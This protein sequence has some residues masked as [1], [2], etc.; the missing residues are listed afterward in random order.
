MRHLYQTASGGTRKGIGSGRAYCLPEA[1][2]RCRHAPWV[3]GETRAGTTIVFQHEDKNPS[4]RPLAPEG[5]CYFEGARSARKQPRSS[6]FHR[7]SNP[8]AESNPRFCPRDRF[9][10]QDYLD[11]IAHKQPSPPK[12]TARSFTA[13]IYV[14]VVYGTRRLSNPLPAHTSTGSRLSR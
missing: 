7:P 12:T 2:S 13:R 14:T 6:M 3:G 8:A 10:Y 1:A 5:L 4:V 11:E 9:S